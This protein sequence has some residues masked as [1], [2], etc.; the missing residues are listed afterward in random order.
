MLPADCSVQV[1][2]RAGEPKELR[3][4]E[5]ARHVLDEA[6]DEVYRIVHG[7]LLQHLRAP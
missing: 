7:F 2:D 3:L 1:F 4:I 5:G 6:A